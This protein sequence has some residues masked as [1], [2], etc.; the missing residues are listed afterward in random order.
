MRRK[1]L[2]RLMMIA[3]ISTGIIATI[4]IVSGFAFPTLFRRALDNK[5]L[6][7][8]NN[9]YINQKYAGW[10]EVDLFEK[11]HVSI[12]AEW[13]IEEQA[14]LLFI[15]NGEKTVA[16]AGHDDGKNDFQ[17]KE[18]IREITGETVTDISF[19][20]EGVGYYGNGASLERAYI[21]SGGGNLIECIILCLKFDH[22]NCYLFF[23]DSSSEMTTVAEAIGYSYYPNE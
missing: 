22:E 23:Y 19:S 21:N 6:H 11:F 14:V 2:F 20:Q 4:C 18:F 15:S 9:P 16:V 17:I 12:P 7:E 10:K 1:S 3:G 5:L 8:L 13:N